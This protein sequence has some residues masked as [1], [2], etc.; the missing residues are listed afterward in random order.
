MMTKRH[1]EP[2]LQS[3]V[4]DS[5]LSYNLID[6]SYEDE[7]RYIVIVQTA[8][9]GP[10]VLKCYSD[11]YTNGDKIDGWA[12]LAQAYRQGG[13]RTPRFYPAGNSSNSAAIS[14]EGI[15]FHVWAEEYM[16]YPTMDDRELDME[17]MSAG[18]LRQLGS[19]MGNMH[20]IALQERIEY[21]WNSPY[22]LLD[23]EEENYSDAKHWYES[24]QYSK[25]DPH[26]VEEIWDV[27]NRKRKELEAAFPALPA[28]GVQGDLSLNNVLIDDD[29]QLAGIIDYNLAGQDKF[30]SYMMQEGIFLCFECYR[31]ERLDREACAYMERRFKYFYEGYAKQY[32]LTQAERGV[33]N[34]LYNII[35]PFRWDKVNNTLQAAQAGAWQEVNE[36]LRWMRRELTREDILDYLES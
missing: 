36:R 11:S 27:Y 15:P 2:I 4:K 24:L 30:V 14:V 16:P 19:C 29:Q 32:P 35:R 20:T 8:K 28:G 3:Y 33:V 5:I 7:Y 18:F 17:D 26:L 10:L 9:H 34:V 25:A 12:R 1:I 21:D 6:N 13:I 31:E 22:V 23:P